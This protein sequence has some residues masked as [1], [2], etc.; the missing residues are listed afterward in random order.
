[1]L[2]SIKI[3]ARGLLTLV[4]TAAAS[5]VVAQAVVPPGPNR[6]VFPRAWDKG[7]MRATVDRYDVEQYRGSGLHPGLEGVIEVVAES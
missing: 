1:M 3:S 7:V 4:A 6:L 2:A 5:T